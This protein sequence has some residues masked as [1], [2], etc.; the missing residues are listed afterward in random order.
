MRERDDYNEFKMSDQMIG[1][2]EERAR[3]KGGGWDRK[4]KSEGWWERGRG[5]DK[6]REGGRTGWRRM[7]SCVIDGC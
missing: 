7:S 4:E 6:G 1:R 2:V 5:W 3:D